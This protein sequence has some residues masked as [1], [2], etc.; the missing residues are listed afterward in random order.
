MSKQGEHKKR[1]IYLQLHLMSLFRDGD[2]LNLILL[3]L[4]SFLLANI[5]CVCL[6]LSLVR[7]HLLFPIL[8]FLSQTL[9]HHTRIRSDVGITNLTHTLTHRPFH[10]SLIVMMIVVSSSSLPFFSLSLVAVCRRPRSL[11]HNRLKIT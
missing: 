3:H 11:T 5:L 9:T 8:I 4:L 7:V 6:S 10:L 2:A 1:V